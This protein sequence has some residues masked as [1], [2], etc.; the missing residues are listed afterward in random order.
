MVPEQLA[1]IISQ[2]PRRMKI[3][4]GETCL[5]GV[6][7]NPVNHSLSPIIH[8][9]A[10]E[11]MNL[12]WCYLAIPCAKENLN[13]VIN[14]LSQINCKGLNIT[15]PHKQSS[16][17]LCK[18]VSFL[19]NKIGAI[20]TLIPNSEGGWNGENTDIKGFM[21]PIKYKNW[22]NKK[23][24]L[25]GCGGSARAV[26]TGLK[27]LNFSEIIVVSRKL[28]KVNEFVKDM[29][30]N[31]KNLDN[32]NGSIK[33]IEEKN[34]H[35]VDHLK[36]ADLI[37]NATPV[38]MSNKLLKSSDGSN[39]PLGKKVWEKLQ[40]ATTFYDLI[41]TP[42]PTTW[43]LNAEEQGCKVIDGLEMLIQQGAASLKLWSGYEDI[44]IE[45]MRQA[46]KKHLK[47]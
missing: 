7:G 9:A 41:Y 2:N 25:L 40:I 30:S 38:G 16:I 34:I 1:I 17:N 11:A 19:A 12:D 8:N 15:I 22:K 44:P 10:L 29:A 4:S 36:N 31:N 13:T 39:M 18:E 6:I 32:Y 23:A 45:I 26:T 5:I 24:V 37:I 43:L 3:I 46:A 20:N 27:L 28:S 14:A 35:L 33:G 47:N 21:E 42:R